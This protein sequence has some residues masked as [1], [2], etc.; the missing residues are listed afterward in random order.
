MLSFGLAVR[1]PRLQ[2]RTAI[3][4]LSYYSSVSL[5]NGHEIKILV[6]S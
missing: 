1:S 4:F 2:V 6:D 3:F 5:T